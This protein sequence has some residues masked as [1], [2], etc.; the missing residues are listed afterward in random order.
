V[1]EDRALDE[2]AE[3]I[4]KLRADLDDMSAT[5]LVRAQR[6]PTGDIEPSLRATAKDGTLLLQGQT[7]NRADYPDLW[8]W[9][10]S[11]GSGGG[12]AAGFGAGNGSTTFV[13]PDMRGR[14]LVGAGQVGGSGTAHT[15]ATTGGATT[16]QLTQA[17]MPAHAHPL[18]GG[19]VPG[20]GDHGGHFNASQV[21]TAAGPDYGVAPWN[22]SGT[23]RGYHDHGV[24]A[25]F[26]SSLGG[27]QAHENRPPFLVGNWLIWT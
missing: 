5:L 18:T 4:K 3:A 7:L 10:V 19:V 2:P 27:D 21:V 23:D 11:N 17:Q 9:A 1:S 20:A 26:C 15:F 6:R 12:L 14:S 13:L 25:V 22:S 16:V 24:V 8:A